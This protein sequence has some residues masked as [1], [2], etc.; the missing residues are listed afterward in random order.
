M[1]RFQY[2][3]IAGLL[4]PA[5]LLIA[6]LFNCV[7]AQSFRISGYVEDSETGER[8]A[9]VHVYL[10]QQ[11]SGVITN[12][13]GF[14]SLNVPA[15]KSRISVSHVSY[16]SAVI[17]L[18]LRTDTTLVILLDPRIVLMDEVAVTSEG[19][20]LA[21]RIQMSHH[22]LP[23][24]QI[25]EIPV[26]LGESDVLRTLQLLP[27][28]QG[29]RE[30]FSQ[31]Y[32]RGGGADQNLILLD[33]QTV[34]NPTHVL[35]IFS[36]F[37]SSALKS[38]ELIKGGFPARYGGR[39][40]SVVNFT[41][42]DGSRKRFAGEGVLGV[43]TSK[44][45]LEGPLVRDKASFLFSGRRT[46]LD[47]FT[48]WF[49]PKGK[50]Y[51]GYFHD[52]NF[53]ANYIINNRDHVHVSGYLGQDALTY[54]ERA[55]G[56]LHIDSDLDQVHQ[57]GNRLASIRW[58]RLI[59]DKI[60][61]NLIT[62][63]TSYR[64]TRE[65][66]QKEDLPGGETE[67]YATRWRS[68]IVDIST[69]LEL[70]YAASQRHYLRGGI[71]YAHHRLSPGNTRDQVIS[72]QQPQLNTQTESGKQFSLNELAVYLED[73]IQISPQVRTN[74]GLR[75]SSAHGDR[76]FWSALEPRIGANI[77]LKKNTSIKLSYALMKQ[78][79]HLLTQLGSTLSQH[80]WIPV[81]D[82]IPPQRSTQVAAGL[83][84]S[85]PRYSIDVS[86]EV[87]RK[88]THG[89]TEFKEH[90]YGYQAPALGWP[91][92]LE[93]G[94][95]ASYGL[96]VLI[97]RRQQRLSGWVGY[98]LAKASKTFSNLNGG[99]SFP[100]NYD[101]R[102]DISIVLNYQVSSRISLG[103]SWVY[104]S[105]YPVWVPAGRYFGR[106]YSSELPDFLDYG[107]VNSARAP[108]VHRLDVSVQFKKEMSWGKR[109]FLLGVYNVY[110]RQN[111]TIVYPKIDFQ[112]TIR[113]NQVSLLQL[114]PALSYQIEF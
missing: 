108:S 78:Y 25:E 81:M 14:Y 21:S 48:R 111:P 3:C 10:D 110:N 69:R 88:R 61:A 79:L 15:S 80:Q 100:D 64:V 57:W 67:S 92:L 28:L 47:L 54:R 113:W 109:T 90:F 34:Y 101:R 53:K 104:G 8:V 59:G 99:L 114:I 37:N 86:L 68:S 103:T 85:F 83:A 23:I 29:G 42:K 112:S 41:M 45:L 71:E 55:K 35:G 16:E 65:H 12:Q 4:G 66:K 84:R 105:G 96:E 94:E 43:L 19:E 70:E 18:D 52:L 60:F 2:R 46:F 89:L 24:Q 17:D 98:T 72:D 91:A 77:A 93:F 75:I 82:G 20:T 73:E 38:V 30:G 56:N 6:G 106:I 87:Y 1:S 107:P 11:R 76:K 31:I 97:E 49:Q 39:L 102:H 9:G 40:S 63:V 5:C 26:L 27:G 32:V 33:G 95:G 44:L 13:Y 7:G 50:T 74:A 22:T 51:G 58:N 62:G 36:V